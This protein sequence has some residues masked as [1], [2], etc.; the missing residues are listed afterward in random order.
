V[1]RYVGEIRAPITTYRGSG[2]FTIPHTDPAPQGVRESLDISRWNIACPVE[3]RLLSV[4]LP[5][6]LVL[7]VLDPAVIGAEF[8]I[9]TSSVASTANVL[10]PRV[11]RL[12]VP[13]LR[14]LGLS[15]T[16]DPVA[17]RPSATARHVLT[18]DQPHHLQPHGP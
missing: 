11:D 15:V 18:G 10:L 4:A 6:L 2:T 3:Q 1:Q 5:L 16:N 12:I 14:L 17:P 9:F 7:P 13:F 8:L